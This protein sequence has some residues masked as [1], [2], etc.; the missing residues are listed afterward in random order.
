MIDVSTS[1]NEGVE[2]IAVA[3]EWT[4]RLAELE[5]QLETATA[6]RDTLEAMVINARQDV[7][8]AMA[9]VASVKTEVSQIEALLVR[10]QG[11][12]AGR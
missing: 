11:E 7:T 4:E 3:N 12:L 10:A 6:Q 9:L 8:C 1:T 2:D 5:I